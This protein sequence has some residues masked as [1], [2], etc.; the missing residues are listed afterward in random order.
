MGQRA[1]REGPKKYNSGI[2]EELKRRKEV[3]RQEKFG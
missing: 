3:R 2:E 1:E